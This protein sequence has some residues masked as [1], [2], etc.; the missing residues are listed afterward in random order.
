MAPEVRT[1]LGPRVCKKLEL[2]WN[3]NRRRGHPFRSLFSVK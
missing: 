2:K 3:L 1:V